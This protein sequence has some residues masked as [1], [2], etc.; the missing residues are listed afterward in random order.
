[1]L[2][3]IVVLLVCLSGSAPAFAGDCVAGSSPGWWLIEDDVMGTR[4]SAEVQHPDHGVACTA[5]EAVMQEMRRI[6]D[7]MSP[8]KEDSIL[9]HLNREGGSRPVFI[10]REL[11]QLIEDSKRYSIMTEGAFDVTYASVG[12]RYDYRNGE[13][14]DTETALELSDAIDYR[15]LVM[16]RATRTVRFLHPDVTVD[17]GGIA[18]GYAVDRG[19]EILR[20]LGITSGRV[21]AGGDSR[22]LG[23]RAGEPW[24]V[25]VRDPRDRARMAAVLPLMD[26]SVSTSGDYE[27]FFEEDGVRYHHIIDPA[28][29]D[30]AREVRSVTILGETATATDALSTS[31]FVLGVEKG[32][33]LVNTLPDVDAVIIDAQGR[34]HYSQ[35]L[36]ALAGH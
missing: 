3:R 21:G 13:R 16:N 12:H 31:V 1:M 6:D 8:Y 19:I 23:D 35:S 29:G 7:A 5:A 34:L 26:A 27:R 28:T 25:G 4:V 15:H 30:S 14:P 24:M 36:L 33:A 17:L 20:K 32:L 11:F 10:G 2:Q 22:I 18:K 9:S